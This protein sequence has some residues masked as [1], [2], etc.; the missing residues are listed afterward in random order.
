[1]A[2]TTEN[3]YFIH[4]TD[5]SAYTKLID[6]KE[7][8][9]L[10]KAPGTVDVTSLSD[11]MKKYLQGLVDTGQLEFKANYDKADFEKMHALE[12]ET[13]KFGIQFGK[14]GENG[15]FLFEGQAVTIVNG[16]GVEAAVDMTTSIA[17]SSDIAMSSTVKATIE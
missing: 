6:I 16:A 7:I 13:H 5:G 1:M 4:S 12:G 3:T 8:P 14:T 10:G 17:V 9:D 15:V 2:I 11:H